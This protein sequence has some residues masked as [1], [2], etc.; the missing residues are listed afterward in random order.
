M[1]AHQ[2]FLLFKQRYTAAAAVPHFHSLHCS[3]STSSYPP[4]PPLTLTPFLALRAIEHYERSETGRVEIPRMLFSL[5]KMDVLEDYVHKSSD[6]ILLKV[7]PSTLLLMLLILILSLLS[8]LMVTVVILVRMSRLH[9][10]YFRPSPV[11][12]AVCSYLLTLCH[13]FYFLIPACLPLLT[14]QWW[15]AY[16]ESVDRLD[17]AKKYY[18]KAGDHLA[19]VRICCFQV[20]SL[21]QLCLFPV[22]SCPLLSSQCCLL[23]SLECLL[24]H[25]LFTTVHPSTADSPS[26]YPLTDCTALHRAT[27]PRQRT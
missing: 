18:K 12:M 27:S 5:G 4:V 23:H 26:S 7:P 11:S 21:A 8:F 24:L 16:L 20:T 22:L 9:M 6:E 13:L 2:C 1:S 15:A 25:L 19:L 17:K 3:Q 10:P 14:T